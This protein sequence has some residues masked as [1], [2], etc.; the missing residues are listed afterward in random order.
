MNAYSI[1]TLL[2]LLLIAATSF[3]QTPSPAPSAPSAP[4]APPAYLRP[5]AGIAA[6]TLEERTA[7]VTAGQKAR[8]DPKVQAAAE[9]VKEA[10][11]AVED[12][13]VAKDKSLAPIIAKAQAATSPGAPRPLL[14][15]T[16]RMQFIAAREAMQGTP[17]LAAAQQASADYRE[18]V[19]QAMIAADPS[20]AA[21]IEKLSQTGPMPMRPSIGSAASPSPSPSASPSPTPH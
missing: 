8:Q 5:G 15:G 13:M 4:S 7:L 11:K 2:P 10:M 3:G 19:R 18:A 14:T 16:E 1:K 12:A 6:L 9:K 21:I 17:E 20:I